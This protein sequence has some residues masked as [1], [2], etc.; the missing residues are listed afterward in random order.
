M[1]KFF[2]R[3]KINLFVEKKWNFEMSQVFISIDK[4]V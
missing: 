1:K 3:L 2:K 4:N